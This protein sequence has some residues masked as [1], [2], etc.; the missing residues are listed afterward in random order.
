[1]DIL[2]SLVMMIKSA[3]LIQMGNMRVYIGEIENMKFWSESL[4]ERHKLGYSHVD[5]QIICSRS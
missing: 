4:K 3:T 1:V 5:W 2:F